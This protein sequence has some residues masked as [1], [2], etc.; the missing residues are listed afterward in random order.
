[1]SGPSRGRRAAHRADR[2]NAQMPGQRTGSRP[3]PPEAGARRAPA[4]SPAEHRA[5]PINTVASP[6]RGEG[7]VQP[8]NIRENGIR[9]AP[10]A[11]VN[12]LSPYA[13]SARAAKLGRN[14]RR[15]GA[16]IWSRRRAGRRRPIAPQAPVFSPSIRATASRSLSRR[17]ARRVVFLRRRPIFQA[18]PLNE[19]D[20]Q[21]PGL[22]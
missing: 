18:R 6:L 11:A 10:W 12:M 7:G 9:G 21:K 14:L 8:P 16:R 3:K 22:G 5:T 2:L 20:A 15:E 19:R 13:A 1:M 17:R 4:L